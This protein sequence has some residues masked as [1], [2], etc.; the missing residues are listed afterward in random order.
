MLP[1]AS[2]TK[3]RD[4]VETPAVLID[5]DIVERNIAR[6]QQHCDRLGLKL[7][8][9]IKT[10]KLPMLALAQIAAGAIGVTAQ[11]IGEAEIMAR[12]G[13]GDILI[14]F[15]IVGQKKLERLRR[16]AETTRLSVSADNV[17]VIDGLASAF[18]DAPKPL[19]V[20]V[21]CDTGMHRCGVTQPAQAVQLAARIDAAPGLRLA[22][23]L[24]YPA[25][26]MSA[27]AAA[28]LEETR[29]LCGEAGL[30]V[31]TISSGGTPDLYR[32]SPTGVLSEYRPGV[33]I[34][35][36]RS[37]LAAGACELADCALTV[38]ATVVSTPAPDRAA[39][40]AG[41]KIL[42]S[43]LFGLEGHG[44]VKG[45]VDVTI[46]RLSEEHGHLALTASDL[47]VGDV[48]QIVPNHACVVSNM[49][50]HIHLVRGDYYVREERVAARGTV[51]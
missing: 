12:A 40:D 15:N 43:D 25:A 46:P 33:Y 51:L 32:M 2:E 22:G 6:C 19:N 42:T 31:E 35:N 50:D 4:V 13:V 41:S 9:H 1:A 49:V 48:V 11:K 28:W 21:E 17:T 34:Y 3:W 10:H 30:A 23:L 20:F 5:L 39:I 24:T 26:G 29:R 38:A 45:L 47:S 44:L 7:R 16:L 36:D 27:E 18:A 14:T 8:P 37:L